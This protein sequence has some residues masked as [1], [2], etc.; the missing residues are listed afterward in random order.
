MNNDFEREKRERFLAI[1][2]FGF[3]DI[4]DNLDF[5]FMGNLEARKSQ[6]SLPGDTLYQ[7]LF[8]PGGLR[9][10]RFLGL[11]LSLRGL[12]RCVHCR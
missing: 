8:A 10:I 7:N 1:V 9:I 12:Q 11:V 5:A 2:D 4:L 3:S 6:W